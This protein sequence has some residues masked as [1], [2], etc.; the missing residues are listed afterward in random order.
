MKTLAKLMVYLG[1]ALFA[2]SCSYW[3]GELRGERDCQHSQ[4]LFEK[5]VIE[6]VLTGDQAFSRIKIEE[7]SGGGVF[8]VGDVATENDREKLRQGI[9]RVLGLSSIDRLM[10]NRNVTVMGKSGG[11]R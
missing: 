3:V 6:P 5:R 8:L 4:Y 10:T 1:L 7:F 9:I 2:L 11:P